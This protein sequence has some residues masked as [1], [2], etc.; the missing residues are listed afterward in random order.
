M[1]IY[2]FKWNTAIWQLGQD[3]KYIFVLGKYTFRKVGHVTVLCF[4]LGG[5]NAYLIGLY[6]V[7]DLE[8][9]EKIMN[10]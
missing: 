9:M 3:Y 7:F 10:L 2:R 4:I 1:E 8:K 5:L 6:F